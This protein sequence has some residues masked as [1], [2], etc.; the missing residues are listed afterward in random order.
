MPG[1]C[2]HGKVRALAVASPQADGEL[3][4]DSDHGGAWVPGF[5]HRGFVG[6]AAPGKTPAPIVGF[7]NKHLNA[8]ISSATFRN[9]WS[10]LGMTHS[11]DNTRIRSRVHAPREYSAGQLAKLSGHAPLK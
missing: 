10:S 1:R 11:S 3:A 4:R 6:L 9:A 2:R 7:L 5:D 8:A